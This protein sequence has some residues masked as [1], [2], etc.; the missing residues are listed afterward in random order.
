M[1]I[2]RPD[3]LNA[4]HSEKQKKSADTAKPTFTACVAIAISLQRHAQRDDHGHEPREQQRGPKRLKLP[5][6]RFLP[7]ICFHLG[8]AEM[9]DLIS[10]HMIFLLMARR[11][12]TVCVDKRSA[13]ERRT[14]T[15]NN[16]FR[17]SLN[18]MHADTQGEHWG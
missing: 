16:C 1:C 4:T 17:D 14:S 7:I 11:P 2:Y 9:T 10:Y 13:G 3:Q 12:P 6:P 15:L 8:C 5:S 18:H